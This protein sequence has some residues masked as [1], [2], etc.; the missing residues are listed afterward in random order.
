MIDP[1]EGP[2]LLNAA[3]VYC[4]ASLPDRV[5]DETL[6]RPTPCAD[7]D[8]RMLLEHT[9]DSIADLNELA[10]TGS[11]DV[12]SRRRALMAARQDQPRRSQVER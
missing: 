9:M 6:R 11:L 4:L 1:L 5:A 3:A 2:S 12:A 8:V 7:W 10:T